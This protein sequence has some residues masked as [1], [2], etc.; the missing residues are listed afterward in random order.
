MATTTAL[1]R[2]LFPRYHTLPQAQS[3]LRDSRARSY[4]TTPSLRDLV[5]LGW[6]RVW[7][8]CRRDAAP[9]PISPIIHALRRTSRALYA[10]NEL[11][12]L[13]RLPTPLLG[14]DARSRIP[15][16]ISLA[17]QGLKSLVHTWAD[18]QQA[19]WDYG[20]SRSGIRR[21]VSRRQT[22]SIPVHD[23]RLD[24]CVFITAAHRGLSGR[25]VPGKRYETVRCLKDIV[26]YSDGTIFDVLQTSA[27][28]DNLPGTPA[29]RYGVPGYETSIVFQT[30]IVS[31]TKS[32]S[33]SQR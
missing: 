22:Q 13:T 28:G 3:S 4:I 12:P 29:L 31:I 26:L 8:K 15:T 1:L 25:D 32:K 33:L 18:A 27:T 7:R 10:P 20:F 9:T 16:T 5:S 30:I 11:S 14:A 24:V 2:S 19:I 17:T 23:V 6:N 21:C